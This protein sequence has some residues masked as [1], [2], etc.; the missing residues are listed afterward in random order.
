M[1]EELTSEAAPERARRGLAVFDELFGDML[2]EPPPRPGEL[3]L[4]AN[5]TRHTETPLDMA[6]SECEFGTEV[7]WKYVDKVDADEPAPAAGASAAE[8]RAAEQQRCYNRVRRALNAE[9]RAKRVST[10]MADR[11][12][13]RLDFMR[14]WAFETPFLADAALDA[15]GS[16]MA[17]AIDVGRRVD[18]TA[19]WV[20]PNRERAA[21][22]YI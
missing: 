21:A 16:T 19:A 11:V 2:A 7:E 18:D 14:R 3:V 9:R 17:I 12:M 13:G 15:L 8:L 5:K 20:G 4:L 6:M 22:G 1:A 10:R